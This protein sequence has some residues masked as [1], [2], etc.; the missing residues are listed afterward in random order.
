ML[1]VISPAKK[2]DYDTPPHTKRYTTPDFLED[3]AE[4]IDQLRVLKPDKI[5]GLMK[6]SAKLATLNSKRYQQWSLPFTPKNSKQAVLAFKGDVY[7]GLDADSLS[8]AELDFA[9]KKL[10]ILSG[11]YGL[12]RP[13]DLIQ[14][15]RLEMGTEFKNTR[16]KDLY[17]FWDDKISNAINKELEKQ[18]DDVLI[19]LAS[20]EY[21]KS[22]KPKTIK[23]RIITPVF[24]DKK[25]SDF[26]VLSFFAKQA[27]GLMGHYI[28]QHKLTNPEDIKD[29]DAAGYRYNKSLSNG[30]KWTFTRSKK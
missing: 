23:A 13:L 30:D 24:K 8:K 18:K 22:L 20:N 12:L 19:N 27:R 6:I 14:P 25:G 1:I 21:F 4:L 17:S 2:L 7:V 29:F 16:S 5:A 9:Q 28:I 3:S 26:K 15:Y 10:R 11:L